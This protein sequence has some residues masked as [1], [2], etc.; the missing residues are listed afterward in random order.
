[1]AKYLVNDSSLTAVADA[2]RTKGGTTER[3][4]FPDGFVSAVEGIQAGGD[5]IVEL[6][7]G[8]ITAFKNDNVTKIKERAFLGCSNLTFASCAN[9]K[10][11][12]GSYAFSSTP[13]QGF[14]FPKLEYIG[15]NSFKSCVNLERIKL[16]S[17]NSGGAYCF[18]WCSGLKSCDYGTPD[19]QKSYIYNEWFSGCTQLK[20][21]IIRYE[22]IILSLGNLDILKDTPFYNGGTGGKCL[23]YSELIGTYQTAT[24]WSSMYEGGTVE[25]LALED[26]TLDGTTAGEID[27]DKVNALF[28]EV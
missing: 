4:S 2:I 20:V 12:E 7:E 28:E 22:T 3:L 10:I 18:R 27:W 14:D 9:L 16:P 25:F 11:I 21:I 13:I 8:T 5:E 19:G 23:V 17:V 24:N 15:A 1:M 26:Y 6:L